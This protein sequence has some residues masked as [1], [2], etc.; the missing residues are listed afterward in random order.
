MLN[1]YNNNDEVQLNIIKRDKNK[2][3][4]MKK[5]NKLA[6]IISVLSLMLSL[7]A[8]TKKEKDITLNI[9]AA[10][11]LQESM[12]ELEIEFKK[13][14][15]QINLQINLGGSGSLQQQIE[16]GANCDVFISAGQEQMNSLEEKGLLLEGTNKT[17][18]YNELVLISSKN[19]E[20]KNL[21]DLVSDDFKH[22]AM[23]EYKSVPVGKY[24]KEVLDN[25]N[26]YNEIKDKLVFGKDVKEVLA[27]VQQG[28]ADLGFVYLS[29]TTGN[30]KVKVEF[31]INEDSYSP[32]KY[33]ISVI[34]QSKNQDEAILFEEFLLSNEGQAILEKYGFK[35]VK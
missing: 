31:K 7:V 30:D 21:D 9:S 6:I 20:V 34:K 12:K 18:L 17:L 14:Q 1:I 32:I 26:R 3:N 24:T 22:I 29:D 33:P 2:E 13:L 23:G 4:K 15:P 10:A 8:C 16:Q 19:N 5:C 11:S 27:W 35:K 25:T 28:N